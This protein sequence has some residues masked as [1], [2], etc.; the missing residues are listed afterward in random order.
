MEPH[1]WNF[2]CVCVCVCLDCAAYQRL[3]V[4]WM[5]MLMWCYVSKSLLSRMA[6]FESFTSPRITHTH[7]LSHLHARS[8]QI[9]CLTC[10]TSTA[11][12]GT[13]CFVSTV[14]TTK[15][16]ISRY[17]RAS[18]GW[19]AN[20]CICW[21]GSMEKE[22]CPELFS[23]VSRFAFS[24]SSLSSSSSSSFFFSF[25]VFFFF[26][27]SFF[28]F[29]FFFFFYFYFFFTFVFFLIF[30][31]VF[32]L[33]FFLFC[34]T[35]FSFFYFFY[36]FHVLTHTHRHSPT[37]EHAHMSQDLSRLGRDIREV[38]IVDNSPASYAFQPQ[39]AVPVESW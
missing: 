16:H 39:N 6:E 4:L 8:M 9:L 35:L 36:F 29:F 33:F 26:F 24:S 25:F 27:V 5:C 12:S 11:Y 13:A 21:S 10:S 15:G 38:I 32:L 7:T 3:L 22:K 17:V 37:H 28:F 23:F 30:F 18:P 31:F 34:S 14:C 1:H 19:I 20:L 2:V